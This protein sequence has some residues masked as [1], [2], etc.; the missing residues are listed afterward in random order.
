M[1][2]AIVTYDTPENGRTS[3]TQATLESLRETVD[4]TQHRV[5][6]SD[7]GSHEPTLQLLAE[8][9]D[10]GLIQE[11][12]FNRE[13]IGTANAINKAWRKRLPQ[14]D[15]VK[16]D[17]DVRILQ[18]GWADWMEDVFRRDKTIGIVGLKRKDLEERPDHENSWF[19]STI[20]MLPHN[21]G[22]RWIVVEEVNHV[23]GTCQAYSRLLLQ[24]IGYLYQPGAYGFDDSL[25]AVRAR[26]AGFK[27]VFL[28][29]FEIDH[30]DV[31]AN[32]YTE[33]KRWYAGAQMQ[34]YNDL[35]AAFIAGR[36]SVY[37]DGT[38]PPEEL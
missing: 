16:M 8:Y 31:G 29:G 17:N 14:E 18:P 21:P 27:S 23:M 32:E 12:I 26:V 6:V 35:A 37:F 13:N 5:I 15:V 30:L 33:W 24:K 3:L 19:K 11:I 22:E 34:T 10:R 28:H 7:N 2:I 9:Q 25:A 1:L 38:S 20:H 36:L 4:F